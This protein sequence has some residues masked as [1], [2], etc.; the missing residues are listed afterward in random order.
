MFI[1]VMLNTV[2]YRILDNLWGGFYCV[3]FPKSS[4]KQDRA[5]NVSINHT[6]TFKD[7][8]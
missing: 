5:T 1:A 3:N 7:Q 6:C 2:S 8:L 4:K